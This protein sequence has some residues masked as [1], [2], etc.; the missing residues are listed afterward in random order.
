MKILG[1]TGVTIS[2]GFK[3]ILFKF[4]VVDEI[5]PKMVIGLPSMKKHCIDILPSV[6]AISVNGVQIPFV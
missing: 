2:V 5:F 6:D 1:Y 3:K 4:T